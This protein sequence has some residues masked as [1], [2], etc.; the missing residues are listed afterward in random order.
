MWPF[1]RSPET[2]AT[3]NATDAVVAAIE[4][5]AAGQI[6]DPAALAVAEA[7]AGLWERALASA[8]VMPPSP[9]LAPLTPGLLALIA[10]GLASRGEF[11]AAIRVDE[12]A[13]LRLVPASGFDV[14][15]GSDARSWRYRVDMAGP[16]RTESE[17][18][19]AAA[20][21]HVRLGADPQ[22]PWRGRSP[23]RRSHATT[24]LAVAIEGVLRRE[25]R[26]P[27][28]RIAPY[29]G[30]LDQLKD[31][32]DALNQGGLVAWAA[33]VGIA[34]LGGQEPSSRRRCHVNHRVTSLW[35]PTPE[36]MQRSSL[37]ATVSS[38]RRGIGGV[39]GGR[40]DG[41]GR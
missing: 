31:Y 8:T 27:V 13:G 40:P 1:S 7:C 36:I 37:A 14:R 23:M 17:N 16:T 5:Q 4:R 41:V 19:P 32:G 15:G 33:A 21:L 3:P 20:V 22:T 35:A 6:P 12:A 18:L 10:R 11:L 29:T 9:A 24:D 26:L 38:R 34:A 25:M 39:F 2:R 28:G 30:G